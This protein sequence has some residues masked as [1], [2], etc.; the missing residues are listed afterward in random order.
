MSKCE[1]REQPKT[2]DHFVILL[3]D[4]ILSILW[5]VIADDREPA[6]GTGYAKKAS[7]YWF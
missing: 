5:R 4:K 2:L 1:R 7:C 3:M 6:G